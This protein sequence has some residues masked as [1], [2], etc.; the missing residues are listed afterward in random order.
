ML[1]EASELWPN[2]IVTEIVA[3]NEFYVAEDYHAEYYRSNIN[4]PY[5]QFVIN[6]KVMK[7]REKYR[8]KLKA[9][10]SQITS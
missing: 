7:F 9:E 10:G 3:L 6:P 4:Q 2:P 8:E 1:V 5:C